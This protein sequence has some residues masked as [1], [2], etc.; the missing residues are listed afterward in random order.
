[1]AKNK[2]LSIINVGD[3][4]LADCALRGMPNKYLLS[5]KIKT[6]SK[7]IAA[8]II[9]FFNDVDLRFGNLETPLSSKADNVNGSNFLL[10]SSKGLNVLKDLKFDI[11]TLANNHILEHGYEIA[12]ETQSLLKENNIRFCYSPEHNNDFQIVK[13]NG[14]KIGFIGYGLRPAFNFLNSYDLDLAERNI[15]FKVKRLDKI[16]HDSLIDYFSS[17]NILPLIKTIKRVKSLANI[18][19]LGLHWGY[20]NTSVP[21]LLQ[22]KT[23]HKL[24]DEGV[25][26]IIGSHPHHI[27]PIEVYKGKLIA[28]SLGN[29]IF[30]MWRTVNRESLVIKLMID[31]DLNVTHALFKSKL[32]QNY[33]IKLKKINYHPVSIRLSNDEVIQLLMLEGQKFDKKK[34]ELINSPKKYW[35]YC[36]KVRKNISIGSIYD[37]IKSDLPLSFKLNLFIRKMK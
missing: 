20:M 35:R 33:L 17:N 37:F 15:A 34:I 21:S 31:R 8:N 26:V 12:K 25:D 16:K 13:K 30:D 1:M 7:Q 22:I 19:I 14:I 10:G 3:I 11:L 29:F 6:S 9:D 36:L 28:Y 4:M 5:Q 18:I 27:Q 2:Y 32:C 24:I 23:A